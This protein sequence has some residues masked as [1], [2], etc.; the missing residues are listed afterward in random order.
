MLSGHS[1][2]LCLQIVNFEALFA[3]NRVFL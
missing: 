2:R 1:K 3:E